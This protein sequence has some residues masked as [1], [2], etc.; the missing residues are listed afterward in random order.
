MSALSVG[1]RVFLCNTARRFNTG[2]H[3]RWRSQYIS[4]RGIVV[5]IREYRV[6]VQWDSKTYPSGAYFYNRAGYP[7]DLFKC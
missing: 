7:N 5:A 4:S 1:D 2:R 3:F 6:W